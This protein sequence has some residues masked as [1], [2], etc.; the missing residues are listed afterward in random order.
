MDAMVRTSYP[1]PI[2]LSG[3]PDFKDRFSAKPI[4]SCVLNYCPHGKALSGPKK[5]PSGLAWITGNAEKPY[6]I[7][8]PIPPL[9]DRKTRPLQLVRPCCFIIENELIPTNVKITGKP[10]RHP[11]HNTYHPFLRPNFHLVFP[12]GVLIALQEFQW[13]FPM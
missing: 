3:H 13:H 10:Q 2:K 7:Q 1:L 12:R 11:L 6:S 5:T 9:H 8:V 4:S